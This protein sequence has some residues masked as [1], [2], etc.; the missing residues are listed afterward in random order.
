MHCKS[1]RVNTAITPY[2]RVMHDSKSQDDK[3]LGIGHV[4]F[5]ITKSCQISQS[6]C[7]VRSLWS[8]AFRLKQEQDKIDHPKHAS[9]LS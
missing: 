2:Y 9:I 6:A 3:S 1:C 4:L 5:V 7:N 8:M